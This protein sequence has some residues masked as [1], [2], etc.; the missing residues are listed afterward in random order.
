MKSALYSFGKEKC[1]QKSLTKWQNRIFWDFSDSSVGTFTR[2]HGR[3]SRE[4]RDVTRWGYTW[5][6]IKQIENMQNLSK[7]Y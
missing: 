2:A 7:M 6:T 3:Y 4:F 5:D 1:P